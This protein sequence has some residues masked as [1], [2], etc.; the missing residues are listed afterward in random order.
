MRSGF[1]SWAARVTATGAAI[2]F[3]AI[4][5]SGCGTAVDA[6][7]AVAMGNIQVATSTSSGA[8]RTGPDSLA[9]AAQRLDALTRENANTASERTRV[10]SLVT[11]LQKSISCK[12]ESNSCEKKL[13]LLA[14]ERVRLDARIEQLPR[15]VAVVQARVSYL[16]SREV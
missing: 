14:G 5:L 15:A 12:R 7:N 4:G 11:T 16:Q 2:A 8:T 1:H 6:Q 10:G 9:I 13:A 3:S